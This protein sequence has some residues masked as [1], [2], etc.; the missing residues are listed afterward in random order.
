M[1]GD[2]AM[3]KPCFR[4]VRNHISRDH[5]HRRHGGNVGSH[6]IDQDGVS[7]RMRRLKVEVVNGLKRYEDMLA[8]AHGQSAQKHAAVGK[9]INRLKRRA[10]V[11]QQDGI[12]ESCSI[13]GRLRSTYQL[14]LFMELRKPDDESER[15]LPLISVRVEGLFLFS[16][17]RLGR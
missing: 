15:S 3:K 16:Y 11:R 17:W 5:L 4:V 13:V 8:V 14:S 12:A 6:L 2:M 1:K 9:P 7:I 10:Y